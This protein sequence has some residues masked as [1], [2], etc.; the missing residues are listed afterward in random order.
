MIASTVDFGSKCAEV[1]IVVDLV[2]I[3]PRTP[4]DKPKM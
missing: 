2:S 1:N 4:A 3:D